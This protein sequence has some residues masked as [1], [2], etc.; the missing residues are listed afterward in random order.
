[1]HFPT[2]LGDADVDLGGIAV[3]LVR[4]RHAT[5]TDDERDHRYD[6]CSQRASRPLLHHPLLLHRRRACSVPAAPLS[7]TLHPYRPAPY[8]ATSRS[9]RRRVPVCHGL[10]VALDASPRVP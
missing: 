10:R 1:A 2:L 5:R 4:Q 7:E 3:T 9:W 8:I 6:R